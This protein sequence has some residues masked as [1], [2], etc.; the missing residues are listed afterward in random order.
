VVGVFGVVENVGDR[1]GRDVELL[2]P[3][4]PGHQAWAI[5]APAARTATVS[6]GASGTAP[7]TGPAGLVCGSKSSTPGR[8]Q[9]LLALLVARRPRLAAPDGQGKEGHLARYRLRGPHGVARFGP[10]R[11]AYEWAAPG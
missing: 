5:R 9:L 1:V 3:V 7:T 6:A 2:D 4:R 11:E 8:A 10:A